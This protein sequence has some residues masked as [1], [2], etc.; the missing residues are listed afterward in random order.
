VPS[1][2]VRTVNQ[3]RVVYVLRNNLPIPV[4]IELGSS[5]N[6]YSQI[7]SGDIKEGDPI[8]IN[9]PSV[10]NMMFGGGF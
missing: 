5:A 6:N 4:T 7:L 3:E 1:R 9:P 2:A 8:I 10:P